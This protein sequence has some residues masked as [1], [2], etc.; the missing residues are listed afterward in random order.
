M[1]H[2]TDESKPARGRITHV[3][4]AANYDEL[5]TTLEACITLQLPFDVYS[6]K[7]DGAQG[8]FPRFRIFVYEDMPN[9]Q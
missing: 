8:Q 4:Q 2:T 1:K 7:Y 9:V 6:L 3:I 5:I